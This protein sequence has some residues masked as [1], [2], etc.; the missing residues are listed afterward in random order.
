[1]AEVRIPSIARGEMV[2]M[3]DQTASSTNAIDIE[4]KPDA[5]CLLNIGIVKP[6]GAV[7]TVKKKFGS[8][9]ATVDL[10][11]SADATSATN[12]SIEGVELRDGDQIEVDI[13]TTSGDKIVSAQA[14][15][16]T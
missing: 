16:L 2:A 13:D 15:R 8:G 5:A 4:I 11:V 1:M 7:L 3:E 10:I 14:R 9:G 12:V 6:T